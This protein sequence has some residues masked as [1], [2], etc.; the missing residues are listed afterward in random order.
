MTAARSAAEKGASGGLTR[1]SA[2]SP[3]I[4][5]SS[6]LTPATNGLPSNSLRIATAASSAAVSPLL[7]ARAHRSA[8]Q[9]GGG[10]DAAGEIA[11]SRLE[12]RRLGRREHRKIRSKSRR[13]SA[14]RPCRRRNPSVPRCGT[15]T[16]P[17]AGGSARRARAG[18]TSPGNDRDKAGSAFPPSP[19]RWFRCRRTSPSSGTPL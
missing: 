4:C 12:Q 17:A 7:Q 1:A 2:G 9:V 13:P 10:R 3:W 19:A 11:A 18:P 5:A 8:L 16:Y 6:A 14:H 15:E